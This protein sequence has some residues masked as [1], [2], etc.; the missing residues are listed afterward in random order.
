MLKPPDRKA[1]FV[2]VPYRCLLPKNLD[3]ILVTGLGVSAHR[4]AMPVIRMQPDIQNQGYAAGCAAAMAAKSAGSLRQIDIKELQKHLIDI[5]TLPEQVLTEKDS[6]PL[7]PDKLENAVESLVNDFDGLEIVLA[8]LKYTMPLL[9]KAYDNAEDEKAKLKYAHI[10]GMLGHSSG[11][12]TLIKE[13]KSRKWDKGWNFTGMGQFGASI[14]ELDS[15]IIALGRTRDKQG[16]NAIIEKLEQLDTG[17]EFSHY[18]A[19]AIALE[20]LGHPNAAEPIAKL[21]K[22]PGLIGHAF[23]D[24]NTARN[25]TPPGHVDTLTRNWSLRELVLARALYRCGD[26]KDIGKQILTEYANDLRGHYARHAREV[27][28]ER[29]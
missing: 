2:N 25:R 4:D 18:R 17:G 21:L 13:V 16:L 3:G 20:T 27:L 9:R 5:G 10:L 22:K 1:F 23:M 12:G 26:Y 28:K 7:P 11:S 14:S 15:I 24:I 19:V 29:Q 6:Y 8:H